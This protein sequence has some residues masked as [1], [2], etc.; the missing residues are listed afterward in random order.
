MYCYST[1][2]KFS[3]GAQTNKTN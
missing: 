1:F 2:F 3:L